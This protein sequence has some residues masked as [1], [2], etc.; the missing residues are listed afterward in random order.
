MH[1]YSLIVSENAQFRSK[2]AIFCPAWPC[3]LT[4]DLGKQHG[5]S[6]WLFQ[7]LCIISLPLVDSNWNYS[8]ETTNLGQNQRFFFSRV[9]FKIWRMTLK[10]NRAPFLSNIKFVAT[11]HRHMWIQTGVIARKRSIR[12]KI[13]NFF[14]IPCHLQIWRMT[15]ENN[16]HLFYATLSF[17]HHF[18][19]ICEF[20]LGLWSGNG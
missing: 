6:P 19:A 5:T 17:V 10:I 12:V 9:T 8:P 4:D 18:V 16:G 13:S 15:L 1:D 2:S 20:K 14:F 7:A 11:F 3:I